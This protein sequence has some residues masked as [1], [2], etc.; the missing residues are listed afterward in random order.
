M[1]EK[2]GCMKFHLNGSIAFALDRQT[3]SVPI[4]TSRYC[5]DLSGSLTLGWPGESSLLA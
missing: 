5:D 3:M 4:T 2:V 1:V